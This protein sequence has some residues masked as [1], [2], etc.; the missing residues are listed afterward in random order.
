VKKILLLLV[1]AVAFA[2][3]AFA[4]DLTIDARIDLSGKDFA[5]SYFSFKG[6]LAAI[7]KA[8]VDPAKV[9][10]LSGASLPLLATEKWNTFR[11]DVKGKTT[12]PGG[13]QSLLKY[14]LS[15]KAQYAAD[16][17]T[18][19]KNP[20][21]SIT[22]QYHHRGTAYKMT[23]DKDGKLSLPVGDYKSRKIGNAP[24]EG[25]V[26]CVI[27]KDFSKDGTVAGIDWAKVWDPKIADGT[28]IAEGN[29]GKTGKITDDKGASMMYL[30]TGNLLVTLNGTI[31][32]VKGELNAAP[33]W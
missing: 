22:I 1:A 18:A 13:I 3:G 4:A 10:A 6:A 21:G 9:D 20:D 19:W 7:E 30:W 14:P 27:S 2:A 17:P 5:N 26:Q 33:L 16:L 24:A 12:F 11:P 8:T 25:K 15:A 32:T 23:T 29:S 28:V 31:L